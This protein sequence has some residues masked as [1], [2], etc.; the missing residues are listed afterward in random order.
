MEREDTFFRRSHCMTINGRIFNIDKPLV[1]GIINVTPDSFHTGSRVSSISEATQLAEKQLSEGA[2][3]LDLGAVSTRPGACIIEPLEE[4]KRL[5]PVLKALAKSFP[6][7]ILSV[8]TSNAST[9]KMAIGEGA[10]IINDVTGGNADT[11]MLSTIGKL[12]VPFITMHSRGNSLTMNELTQYNKLPDDIIQWFLNEHKKHVAAGIKDIILDPGIGFAKTAEQNFEII[13]KLD[14]FKILEK[15]IL[16]G[17]SRK[18][19]IYNTLDVSVEN[20]L[21]GTTAIH[22]ACLMNGASILRVHD[23][24]EAVETV[25]LYRNLRLSF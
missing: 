25:K 12:G 16:M 24:K 4:E 2:D 9:A 19:F 17:V 3:W 20:S 11:A 13:G 23:V 15:P 10:A 8:D 5:I 7:V 14:S 18:R 6:R 1:M 22:M 21:N